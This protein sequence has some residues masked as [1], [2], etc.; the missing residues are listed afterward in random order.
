LSKTTG[1][2]G[3]AFL[4]TI[5]CCPAFLCPSTGSF[6]AG[7]VA[8][9]QRRATL[10]YRAEVQTA[11]VIAGA[12]FRTLGEITAQEVVRILNHC[13]LQARTTGRSTTDVTI[14][15][16]VETGSISV[17]GLGATS[18]DIGRTIAFDV[19]ARTLLLLRW[20]RILLLF[21]ARKG[22]LQLNRFLR[23]IS[24]TLC[25]ATTICTAAFATAFK[26]LTGI[27]TASGNKTGTETR[28]LC[29]VA[30]VLR[31]FGRHITRNTGKVCLYC[32]L[33]VGLRTG[34][35]IDNT[36]GVVVFASL[37][38]GY[39]VF[40]GRAATATATGKNLCFTD[41]GETGSETTGAFALTRRLTLAGPTSF[42]ST[43]LS[44]A[45]F[46]DVGRALVKA[47]GSGIGSTGRLCT[48]EYSPAGIGG[49]AAFGRSS[50]IGLLL[51]SD[52]AVA[53]CAPVGF[54][55]RF[56]SATKPDKQGQ[57]Q[58]P[59]Q[60]TTPKMPV[61]RGQGGQRHTFSPYQHQHR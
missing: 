58:T 2:I 41:S 30:G 27:L 51:D 4:E 36:T 21:A 9:H 50:T 26:R 60:S 35:A 11:F 5:G 56:W 17:A 40:A 54:A 22:T 23:S 1:V 46:G 34:K 57:Q 47:I 53:V 39:T 44:F 12:A 55:T 7:A 3:L 19:I 45:R 38:A 14:F 49:N 24:L 37:Q 25:K 18:G 48:G 43:P 16:F 61:S 42:D 6:G 13:R 15:A 29:F 59:A 20:C 10:L 52:S 31:R 32:I 8:G 28:D 33:R